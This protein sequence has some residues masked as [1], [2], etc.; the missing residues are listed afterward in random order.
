[1][2]ANCR[3]ISI[4]EQRAAMK[5]ANQH[6]LDDDKRYSLLRLSG[7]KL[8]D[9][10]AGETIKSAWRDLAASMATS[11]TALAP[12]T[13]ASMATTRALVFYSANRRLPASTFV[14]TWGLPGYCLDRNSWVLRVGSAGLRTRARRSSV[15]WHRL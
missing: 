14:D 9:R 15:R 8:I 12:L 3:A 13:P 10:R 11:N 5:M 6:G 1:V 2:K 4:N 7:T